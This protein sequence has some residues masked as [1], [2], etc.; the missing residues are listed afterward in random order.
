METEITNHGTRLK[1]TDSL[2]NVLLVEIGTVPY[3]NDSPYVTTRGMKVVEEFT[4]LKGKQEPDTLLV[5][6]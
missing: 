4:P 5:E 2:G 6:V 3:Y 1:V